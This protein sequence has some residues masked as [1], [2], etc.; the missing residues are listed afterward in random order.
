MVR[1][2]LIRLVFAAATSRDDDD[3][4]HFA[5]VTAWQ[6]GFRQG[7]DHLARAQAGDHDILLEPFDREG[8]RIGRAAGRSP[9]VAGPE[10]VRR[11]F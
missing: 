8:R 4:R 2:P 9:R 7:H 5:A 1:H 11:L 3:A 6:P 10:T